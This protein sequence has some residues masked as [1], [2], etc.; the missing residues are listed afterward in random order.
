MGGIKGL[1]LSKAG[2][3]ISPTLATLAGA[4][5]G[6][7]FTL[8]SATMPPRDFSLRELVTLSIFLVLLYGT[9]G[10]IFWLCG[11][12]SRCERFIRICSRVWMVMV[13]G[14]IVAFPS[15]CLYAVRTMGPLVVMLIGAICATAYLAVGAAWGIA[16]L[17]GY[18]ASTFRHSSKPGARL[19]TDGWDSELV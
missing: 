12:R 9:F 2:I 15:A 17:V 7:I 3:T 11:E 5:V 8:L 13:L 19:R 18:L 4:A 16:H 14:L 6:C 1:L 10:Y